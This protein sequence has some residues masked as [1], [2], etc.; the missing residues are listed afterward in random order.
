MK[1]ALEITTNIGCPVNC[2]KYC[3]QEV[4][5]SR[6]KCE[7][8]MSVETYQKILNNVPD[9]VRILFA[10]FSEPLKNPKCID[11]F[12]MTDK[13]TLELYTTL[14]GLKDADM[15][16]LKRIKFNQICIHLPD[17][18]IMK[19]PITENYRNH[20]FELIES[21]SNVSFNIMNNNFVTNNREN[22]TRG[23]VKK[24]KRLG[25]CARFYQEIKPVVLPNGDVYLCC[26][27]FGLSSPVGNLTQESYVDIV[28]RILKNKNKFKTCS[29]C[30][31]NEP[32]FRSVFRVALHNMRFGSD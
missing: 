22:T 9:Y 4:L 3:P 23:L 15:K 21:N 14:Y 11:F 18:Q 16:E 10:G 12:K 28:E 7:K 8:N 6:Y 26:M 5:V 24:Q 30:K 19:E 1:Y 13:H 2:S 25:W 32:Y 20:F 29:T 17:G 31:Y 27:D